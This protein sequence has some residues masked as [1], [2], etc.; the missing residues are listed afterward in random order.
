MRLRTVRTA[1]GVDWRGVDSEGLVRGCLH[2]SRCPAWAG[3]PPGVSV[4][5]L[6]GLSLGATHDLPGAY[7]SAHATSALRSRCWGWTRDKRLLFRDGRSAHEQSVFER[8]SSFLHQLF[9]WEQGWETVRFC[10]LCTTL[11]SPPA[12]LAPLLGSS[13]SSHARQADQRSPIQPGACAH[14][15]LMMGMITYS[16]CQGVERQQLNGT[17]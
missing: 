16:S 12:S 2:S 4:H 6:E 15:W 7:L 3:P 14:P 9:H 17:V 1:Q 10:A 8:R 5:S 11:V 13:D